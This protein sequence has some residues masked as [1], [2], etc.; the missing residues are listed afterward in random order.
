MPSSHAGP[1]R[2]SAA[3][4]C[5]SRLFKSAA[6]GSAL[7]SAGAGSGLQTITSKRT[8]LGSRRT[9]RRWG[10]PACARGPHRSSTGSPWHSGLARPV[11]VVKWA[12][13]GLLEG[14]TA[15]EHRLISMQQAISHLPTGAGPPLAHRYTCVQ[16]HV[17]GTSS[18]KGA[19]RVEAPQHGVFSLDPGAQRSRRSST[20]PK[21]PTN[22]PKRPSPL[23]HLLHLLR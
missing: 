17:L 20:S 13:K 12:R 9:A 16:P 1:M 8:G 5:S 10:P 15:A 23:L 22:H 18:Y 4:S 7:R 3:S 2:S 21:A 11:C 19:R 6:V 14:M